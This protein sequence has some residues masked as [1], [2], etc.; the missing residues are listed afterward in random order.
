MKEAFLTRLL[1]LLSPEETRWPE[2]NRLNAL[3]LQ[4]KHKILEISFKAIFW[5]TIS[6]I[7]ALL[8]GQLD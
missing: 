5:T 2:N 4:R 6:I 3:A 1:F 8:I 7:L